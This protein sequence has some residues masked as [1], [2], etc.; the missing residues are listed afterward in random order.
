MLGARVEDTGAGRA[1]ANTARTSTRHFTGDLHAIAAAM[2]LLASAIDADPLHGE[3]TSASLVMIA[4]RRCPD[5]DGPRA[6]LDHGP[7]SARSALL[8]L[9]SGFDITA[10]S[11]ATALLATAL[12]RD[13]LRRLPR[14]IDRR[15]QRRGCRCDAEGTGHRW[16]DR[17][18]RSRTRSSRTG[19]DHRG[20]AGAGLDV[21]PFA[22]DRALEQ[23][24]IGAPRAGPK[25]VELRR[26]LQQ[27]SPATSAPTSSSILPAGLEVSRPTSSSSSPRR[28]R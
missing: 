5:I 6:A 3:T 17:P 20:R 28:R 27:A 19:A 18:F 23:L 14:F 12:D 11:E 4:G 15:N 13:D 24:P 10:A 22:G 26:H 2:D 8:A 25:L 16:R 1:Q 9:E 21:R 7:A